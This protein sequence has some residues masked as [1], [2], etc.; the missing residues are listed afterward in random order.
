MTSE[1]SPKKDS[2]PDKKASSFLAKANES[3]NMNT[4]RLKRNDE[5]SPSKPDV[6]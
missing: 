3:K 4:K 6:N 2:S 1:S 5:D